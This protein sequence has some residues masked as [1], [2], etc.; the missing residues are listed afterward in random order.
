MYIG[1]LSRRQRE[2]SS[3]RILR[4]QGRPRILLYL[5]HS[6]RQKRRLWLH[7]SSRHLI[8]VSAAL[9][10]APLAWATDSGISVG[11][12]QQPHTN[13]PGLVVSN[14]LSGSVLKKLC[15]S[16]STPRILASFFNSWVESPKMPV[17]S[18]NCKLCS[19]L[20]FAHTSFDTVCYT[21]SICDD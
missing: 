1:C 10:A 5:C 18:I 19:L 15:S 3:K 20:S 8:T 13:I 21:W 14:G 7:S 16:S 2:A 12:R 9:S 17:T 6:D 11:S 4:A